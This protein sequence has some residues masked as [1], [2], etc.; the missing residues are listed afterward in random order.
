MPVMLF[1]KIKAFLLNSFPFSVI[2]ANSEQTDRKLTGSLLLLFATGE[3][4]GIVQSGVGFR[5]LF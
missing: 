1:R 3:S 4:I 2:P 5:L